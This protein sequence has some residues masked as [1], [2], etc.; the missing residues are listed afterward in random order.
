M[1]AAMQLDTV[2]LSALESVA[3]VIIGAVAASSRW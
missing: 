3:I 2:A 1:A